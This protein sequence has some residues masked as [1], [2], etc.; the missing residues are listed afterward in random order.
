MGS[1]ERA[2]VGPEQQGWGYEEDLR[3]L[4]KRG[5]PEMW[6]CGAFLEVSPRKVDR[7]GGSVDEAGLGQV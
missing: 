3:G 7:F 5:A 1:G 6:Q 4:P 2:E